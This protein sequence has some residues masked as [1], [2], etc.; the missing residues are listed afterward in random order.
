[1]RVLILSF[2]VIGC[3]W[4]FPVLIFKLEFLSETKSTWTCLFVCFEWFS[5]LDLTVLSMLENVFSIITFSSSYPS[6]SLW[7]G[8]M[9]SAFN[10]LALYSRRAKRGENTEGCENLYLVLVSNCD[11]HD[12]NGIASAMH[13]SLDCHKVWFKPFGPVSSESCPLDYSQ[14]GSFTTTVLIFGPIMSLL[15]IKTCYRDLFVM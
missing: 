5:F 14:T 3:F 8:W 12:P 1:M 15:M 10:S 7:Q 11:F 13:C 2:A 6:S 4:C 9:P